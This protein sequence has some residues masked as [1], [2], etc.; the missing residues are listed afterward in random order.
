[1]AFASDTQ[2]AVI[3]VCPRSSGTSAVWPGP[4]DGFFVHNLERSVDG[5]GGHHGMF[6]I[7]QTAD[8][9]VTHSTSLSSPTNLS[10][11]CVKSVP[12]Y[13][14]LTA[15]DSRTPTYPNLVCRGAVLFRVGTK[16]PRTLEFPTPG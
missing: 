12:A 14:T 10:M 3:H 16:Y 8:G 11:F 4:V 9:Q 1:V 13:P 5:D 15:S 6:V 7:E 2:P